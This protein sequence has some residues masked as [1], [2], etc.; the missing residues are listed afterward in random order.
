MLSDLPSKYKY[1]YTLERYF[2]M[3][4]YHSWVIESASGAVQLWFRVYDKIDLEMAGGV[5][6][7]YRECPYYMEG[8]APSYHNCSIVGGICWHDGSSMAADNFREVMHNEYAP[9]HSLA[10]SMLHD[11]VIDK[12]DK[13]GDV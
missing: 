13:D 9:N 5:E 3:G 8:R 1:K 10:F 4:W 12:E 2:N 11:Y 6:N 7:H